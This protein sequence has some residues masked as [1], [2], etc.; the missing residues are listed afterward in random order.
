MTDN[1]NT[2]LAVILSGLVLITTTVF[3]Q[4]AADGKTA[5]AKPDAGRTGQAD[6][7]GNPGTTPQP[8]NTP[9]ATQPASAAPVISHDA[10]LAASPRI[11]IETRAFPAASL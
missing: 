7:A 8:G 3:L 1:R 10:A 5:R 6:A 9:A 2:I 4:R 11:K